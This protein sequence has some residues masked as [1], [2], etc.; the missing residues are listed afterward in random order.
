MFSQSRMKIFQT[1]R[2][3]Y[4]MAGISAS[5]QWTQK[6]AFNNKELFGFLIFGFVIVSQ[7]V[8]IFFVAN[9]LME[10]MECASTGSGTIIMFACFAGIVFRRTALF[11]TIDNIEKLIDTSKTNLNSKIFDFIE[12]KKKFNKFFF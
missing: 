3:K 9:D 8:Y 7:L 11:E 12:E 10:Y 6:Y 4:A 5:Q 1:V 2:K